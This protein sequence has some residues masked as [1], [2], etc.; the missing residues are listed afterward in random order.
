MNFIVDDENMREVADWL[1]ANTPVD[2]L[3]FYGKHR[4]IHVSYAPEPKGE[5]IELVVTASGKQVPRR[6]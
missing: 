3:Y 4:P 6:R 5:Y 2:R 1:I